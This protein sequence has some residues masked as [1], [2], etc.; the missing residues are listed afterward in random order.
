MF[1]RNVFSMVINIPVRL[2][3]YTCGWWGRHQPPQIKDG[4]I[5]LDVGTGYESS[6][7]LH[8]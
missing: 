6:K 5:V 8:G 1:A 7:H 3:T 4:V 2:G